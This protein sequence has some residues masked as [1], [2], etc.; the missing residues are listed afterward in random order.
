M[1]QVRNNTTFGEKV[2]LFL[3]GVMALAPLAALTN[4]G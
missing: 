2:A 3:A 1:A 4:G